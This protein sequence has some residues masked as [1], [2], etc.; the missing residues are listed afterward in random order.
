MTVEVTWTPVKRNV[1][2]SKGGSQVQSGTQAIVNGGSSMVI[3][4]SMFW[5]TSRSAS[6]PTT[7]VNG[8][9]SC[10]N[11]LPAVVSYDDSA[12]CDIRQGIREPRP[13]HAIQ[14]GARV[15]SD[16]LAPL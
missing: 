11:F 5:R 7:R 8:N 6:K 1:R 4:S 12:L 3:S 9:F 10:P 2:C 16:L 14:L 15:F 13:E